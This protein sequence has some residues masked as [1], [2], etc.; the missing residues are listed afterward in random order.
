MEKNKELQKK[1]RGGQMAIKGTLTKPDIAGPHRELK[2]I[3]GGP[4][5]PRPRTTEQEEK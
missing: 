2:H 1:A 3:G 4:L 5:A